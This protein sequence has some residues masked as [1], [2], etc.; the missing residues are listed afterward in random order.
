MANLLLHPK[1]YYVAITVN[2]TQLKDAD[3][4]YED[5]INVLG[6]SSSRET[7]KYLHIGDGACQHG[8][9][10][11]LWPKMSDM[12]IKE[13]KQ[14]GS[15]EEKDNDNHNDVND[16]HNALA[17]DDDEE[18]IELELVFPLLEF[19]AYG[20]FVSQQHIYFITGKFPNLKVFDCYMMYL[21]CNVEEF[22]ISSPKL[23][24]CNFRQGQIGTTFDLLSHLDMKNF[25][26]IC[27]ESPR[28]R[29]SLF[30]LSISPFEK[31]SRTN[32][33]PVRIG[34]YD[35]STVVAFTKRNGVTEECLQ[36]I[37]GIKRNRL[38]LGRD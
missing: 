6:D 23:E 20:G 26:A 24:I 16:D 32:D 11:S 3:M 7:L 19:Y 2:I 17:L 14:S 5:L 31:Y 21:T 30:G 1:I 38:K 18:E 15:D 9:F 22:I 28:R 27:Y 13:H 37:Q 35:T 4:D 10:R 29:K 34:G 8:F 25:K 33:D 12:K 36:Q